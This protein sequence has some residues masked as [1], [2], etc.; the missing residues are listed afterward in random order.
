[1]SATRHPRT[2]Y[3]GLAT[4]ETAVMRNMMPVGV[5]HAGEIVLLNEPKA[6]GVLVENSCSG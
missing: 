6:E 3:S 2:V 5:E 4:L 1:M